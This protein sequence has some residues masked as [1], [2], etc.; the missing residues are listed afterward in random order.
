MKQLIRIVSRYK[1]ESVSSYNCQEIRSNER[2]S[3]CDAGAQT[4]GNL[5]A[6]FSELVVLVVIKDGIS[7]MSTIL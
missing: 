7:V 4:F 5:I 6:G 3:W 2:F 1:Y